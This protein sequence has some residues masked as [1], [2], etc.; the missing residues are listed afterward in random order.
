[1]PDVFIKTYNRI[2]T[3]FFSQSSQ[4]EYA[5]NVEFVLYFSEDTSNINYQC[6]IC[7]AVNEK[8]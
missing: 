4:Y 6:E 1:M 7:I 8:E 5:E 2:V 3:E